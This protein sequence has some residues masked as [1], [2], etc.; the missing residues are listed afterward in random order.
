MDKKKLVIGVIGA[1]VHAVGI[2]ILQHA[3]EE[4]GFEVVNL[5]VMVSQE[6][7]IAAAIET[8]ADAILVS[9]LYGHGELDCRGLRDKCDESGL[10]DIL[11][12]VGGNIVV[13]KQPFDEVEKRFKA[14]GFDRVFGPGTAPETTV[15][16]L[17]EDLKVEK[18]EAVLA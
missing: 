3:F 9:S 7:Y 18:P 5:G 4:A 16:A 6:E 1:D 8:N 2:S 12:Y 13:G 11:L 14:M 17:Y 10:K 15:A